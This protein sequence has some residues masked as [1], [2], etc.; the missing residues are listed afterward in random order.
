MKIA[1]RYG[2]PLTYKG[3]TTKQYTKTEKKVDNNKMYWQQQ[4]NILLEA[5]DDLDLNSAGCALHTYYV[6]CYNDG[7]DDANNNNNNRVVD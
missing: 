7:D 3:E 4:T 6:L 5:I 1:I 2:L